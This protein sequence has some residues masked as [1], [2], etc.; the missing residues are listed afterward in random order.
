MKNRWI[1]H[2]NH[3]KPLKAAIILCRKKLMVFIFSPLNSLLM[4]I[5]RRLYHENDMKYSWI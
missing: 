4:A 2:G 5:I 3:E 1:A